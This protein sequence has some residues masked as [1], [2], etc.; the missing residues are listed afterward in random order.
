M[1]IKNCL[2]YR[3]SLIYINSEEGKHDKRGIK[4][5]VARELCNIS[6]ISVVI[7]KKREGG[8]VPFDI[9]APARL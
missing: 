6:R 9:K 5:T 1:T 8:K 2:P 7:K 4:E 3:W